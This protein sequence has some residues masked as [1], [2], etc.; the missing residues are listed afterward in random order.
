MRQSAVPHHQASHHHHQ[1]HQNNKSSPTNL[2]PPGTT[3]VPGN[4]IIQGNGTNMV[5]GNGTDPHCCSCSNCNNDQTA[6]DYYNMCECTSCRNLGNSIDICCQ[7]CSCSS[8]Y[9]RYHVASMAMQE[10]TL[11]VCL[12]QQTADLTTAVSQNGQ[13]FRSSH[14]F[15]LKSN[16]EVNISKYSK[17][18]DFESIESQAK[19]RRKFNFGRYLYTKI[20]KAR[21]GEK[22]S[23]CLL[24]TLALKKNSYVVR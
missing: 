13:Y 8:E 22:V 24:K 3:V 5:P 7:C 4:G 2:V 19:T 12:Q 9:P 11:E 23:F 17:L 16:C 10:D 14:C 21:N 18:F 1:G 6:K 15:S 20:C